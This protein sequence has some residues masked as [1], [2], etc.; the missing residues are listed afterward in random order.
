MGNLNNA[1]AAARLALAEARAHRPLT[2]A[3]RELVQQRIARD[4][5]HRAELRSVPLANG[6]PPDPPFQPAGPRGGA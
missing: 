4:L 2:E 3:E 1:E 6:D 5:A